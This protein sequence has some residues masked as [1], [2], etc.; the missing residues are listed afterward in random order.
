MDTELQNALAF[1]KPAP[2]GWFSGAKRQM[3]AAGEWIWETIQGDFNDNQTTGQVVTGT[4]I[5]MIPLV[6]QI[7]DVRDLVANCKKIKEED[8]NV[9][10]W[11]ALVLTLIGCFPTLGSLCKGAF[12][13]LFLKL[14]KVAFGVSPGSQ[15]I[16]KALEGSIQLLN[17]FLDLKATRAALKWA[18]IPNA[19]RYLEKMVREV[20]GAI[21]TAKL[22]A[23]F[24]TLMDVTKTLL[25]K[26][27]SWGP[28]S[29]KQP[30][31]AL[32][33]TLVEV[34]NKADSMLAKALAPVQDLLD[35][36]A[37][38][39]RVEGDNAYRAHVGNNSHVLGWEKRVSEEIKLFEREKPRWVDVDVKIKYPPL[40][41]LDPHQIEKI[42]RGWPDISKKSKNKALQG[43]FNTF[44]RSM[45]AAEIPP[46]EKLYRVIDPNSSDNSICWMRE[47]EFK[48]L[49]SKNDW[50]RRFAVWKSW[51]ENGEY[52]IY[53]V[54]P[55]QPL[56]VWEGRAGTQINKV[57]EKYSLEGGAVQIVLDP[58]QLKK[59]FTG[60]R[61][62]TG[63]G[64]QD[65]D[66][67]PLSPYLGLP[68]LETKNNW[69]V[70]KEK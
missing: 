16:E 41:Q 15:V 30:I 58:D 35:R 22:L 14:R 34:R 47:G 26:A 12:K 59:E 31:K 45:S 4:L 20:M 60:Q 28:D 3:E 63:W 19:Y 70:P 25:N 18:K 2:E 65:V 27:Q 69:Y 24:D 61:L 33:N 64:Y 1:Y 6:D 29:L 39:L 49:T 46:G 66:S 48:K 67:D 44:D 9:W 17:T 53:T 57:E 42:E 13:V 5:S 8:S 55:G 37:N 62:K 23:V 32:W 43:K 11:V 50:R 56:K 54:P 40:S 52:V 51:N 21:T 7:C 68:R 38:K 36:L 10:S